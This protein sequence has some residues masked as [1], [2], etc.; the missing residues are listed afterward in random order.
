MH[1]WAQLVA[2]SG[3]SSNNSTVRQQTIRWILI[4]AVLGATGLLIGFIY[5]IRCDAQIQFLP[6]RSGDPCLRWEGF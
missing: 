2:D 1:S 3:S 6:G 4:P 5:L